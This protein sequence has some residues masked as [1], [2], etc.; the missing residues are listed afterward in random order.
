MA[1]TTKAP[2]S[3]GSDP[4]LLKQKITEWAEEAKKNKE[5]AK[6]TLIYRCSRQIASGEK[7]GKWEHS[8]FAVDRT[9][10]TGIPAN[11]LSFEPSDF[12]EDIQLINQRVLEKPL[13]FIVIAKAFCV[14]KTNAIL[15][16]DSWKIE[17]LSP[18]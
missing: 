18:S 3:I 2:I 14:A 11:T 8:Q 12:D 16:F 15:S 9:K 7:K 6:I 4:A 10:E 5:L 1:I 17:N 13:P